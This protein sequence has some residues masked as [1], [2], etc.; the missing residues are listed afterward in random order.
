MKVSD[1]IELQVIAQSSFESEIDKTTAMLSVWGDL[2][3]SELEEMPLK[4]VVTMTNEMKAF[5]NNDHKIIG[6]YLQYKLIPNNKVTLGNFI[7]LETYLQ[8]PN[9]LTK[10]FAILYRNYKKNEWGEVLFEPVEFDLKTRAAMFDKV[11]V[12][13]LLGGVN[14]YVKFRTNVIETYKSIFGIGENE[15]PEEIDTT[16][17]NPAEIAEIEK[18]EKKRKEMARYSWESFVYWLAGEDLTKVESVLN[19]PVVYA[20]NMASMTKI[21]NS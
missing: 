2:D 13:F 9:D 21:Y 18:E 15:E 7:D 16:D 3:V 5:I 4:E 8:N 1:Y 14:S 20:L 10:V 12:R 11:D 17:L 19:F 6:E